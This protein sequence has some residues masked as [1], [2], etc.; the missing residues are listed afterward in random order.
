MRSENSRRAPSVNLPSSRSSC[1]NPFT[2]RTPVTSSS[3]ISATSAADCWAAQVAGNSTV[4]VAL[5]T[6]TTAGTTSSAIRVSS[7][8][9][10]SMITSETT[11]STT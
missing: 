5:V 9:S 4:R 7:G 1:P 3:T 11:N 8:D 2:T 6:T 10:V